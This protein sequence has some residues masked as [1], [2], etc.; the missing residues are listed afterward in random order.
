MTGAQALPLLVLEP[1]RNAAPRNTGPA[2]T[3]MF[4][5]AGMSATAYTAKPNATACDSTTRKA[6][7]EHLRPP[8]SIRPILAHGTDTRGSD[9]RGWRSLTWR[10]RSG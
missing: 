6:I 1:V 8:F 10:Y 3:C 4:Q 2:T 7:S 9:G 5:Q